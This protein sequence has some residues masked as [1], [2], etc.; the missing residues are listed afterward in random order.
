MNLCLFKKFRL[1]YLNL[2]IFI[3]V[4]IC[5]LI[6]KQS[7]KK[8]YIFYYEKEFLYVN[9][10]KCNPFHLSNETFKISIDGIEYPQYVPHYMNHSYNFSCLNENKKRKLILVWNNFWNGDKFDYGLGYE[11]PFKRNKCPVYNCEITND[12]TRLNDSSLILFHMPNKIDKLPEYRNQ[13]QKWVFV[14]MESPYHYDDFKQY[15]LLFNLSSTYRR[16]SDFSS[17]YATQK[18]IFI[19]KENTSFNENYDYTHGKTNLASILLSNCRG[20]RLNYVNQLKKYIDVSVYG[21]CGRPCPIHGG[22]CREI[23]S[24][25]HKFFLAFENSICKDYISEK[26]FRTL[27]YDTVPVVYGGGNYDYYVPR[28]GYINALDFKSPKDLAKYLL[29]L[30]SNK[31]AYNSYFKWKKHVQFVHNQPHEGTFCEM[32]LRLNLDYYRQQ[33]TNIIKDLSLFWSKKRD[34]WQLPLNHLSN[35]VFKLSPLF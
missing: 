31:T 16:N 9:N 6:N 2:L 1:A 25:S 7:K 4:A 3:I 19:W 33:E 18:S 21:K 22:D 24:K 13:I 15:N 17:I 23:L 10:S 27:F 29:Y 14:S 5:F 34:C 8:P 35:Q 30:D 20:G 12:R 32:C 11:E 28:S 26:F